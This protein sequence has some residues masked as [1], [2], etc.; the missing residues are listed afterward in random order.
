[1][2]IQQASCVCA[3]AVTDIAFQCPALKIIII[4]I[5]IILAWIV[6]QKAFDRVPHDWIIKSLE[7]IGINNKIISFTKKVMTYWKR[8]MCLHAENKL[9]ET[10]DI[11]I[12]FVEY[13]KETHYHHFNFAFA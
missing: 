3:R 9:M 10:E 11:K 12:N 6:Y 13:F 1:M 5:I 4:T 2:N 7:L 8:R